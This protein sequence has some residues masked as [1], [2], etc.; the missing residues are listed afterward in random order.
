VEEEA[1]SWPEQAERERR[2]FTPDAAAAAVHEPEL[3]ALIR[4]SAAA[5]AQDRPGRES[6]RLPPPRR[7]RAAPA[8]GGW[9][10][11]FLK[12]IM[13][14]EERFFDLFE[15]HAVTMVA[16]AD[17]MVGMFTG[18]ESI[19][20]SCK[21]I[22]RHEHD[23]DDVTRSVL[24]AVRRSFITPFDRSAITALISS[25]DDAVDEMWKT[26]KAI[27]LY[28]VRSFEPQMREIAVSAAEAARLVA[29]GVP[30]LRNI[31]RNG[32]RLHEITE[33]IVHLEGRAD[34]LHEAGLKA[35]FQ[36]HREERV[37]DFIVGREVYS[38]L[39][40]VL[41][42]LEDVADEIQGIVIDHA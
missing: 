40:R 21:A 28:E 23:A 27:T 18:E 37:M 15:R 33:A 14:K 30:L 32:A 36:A 2:W 6:Y 29:E 26:A 10:M 42:R 24:V 8:S 12:A 22:A 7:A 41:D 31:G 16:G 9:T 3:A 34:D 20:A 39:E 17:A 38:H 5:V 13:P 11:N 19:E 25:M 1:S 35:L 4:R